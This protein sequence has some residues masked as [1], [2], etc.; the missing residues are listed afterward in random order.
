MAHKIPTS[1][2]LTED[3]R[4]ALLRIGNG[5]SYAEGVR[6]LLQGHGG[7]ALRRL[8]AD[9][10]RPEGSSSSALQEWYRRAKQECGYGRVH[11]RM[12]P[13]EIPAGVQEEFAHQ[14][15][16]APEEFESASPRDLVYVVEDAVA[17]GLLDDSAQAEFFALL[18][19]L[20]QRMPYGTRSFLH[21]HKHSVLVGACRARDRRAEQ[22]RADRDRRQIE[23]RVEREHPVPEN[24]GWT[25][26]VPD[27][28]APVPD[29]LLPGDRVALLRADGRVTK[30]TVGSEED[31]LVFAW[32]RG[33]DALE[34]WDVIAY[35]AI[36]DEEENDHERRQAPHYP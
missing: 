29:D 20:N 5:K 9:M 13:E 7:T 10:L 17:C 22:I 16:L 24:E 31:C 23:E 30:H 6:R 25:R 11:E 8:E 15:H 14:I 2:T 1:M 35:R 32:T 28:E 18:A 3:E 4:R 33:V 21:Q 27:K 34:P 19:A 26:H 12:L 36:N